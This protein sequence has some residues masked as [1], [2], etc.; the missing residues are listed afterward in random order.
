MPTVCQSV[1]PSVHQ[2]QQDIQDP[3]R[4]SHCNQHA[5]LQQKYN[6]YESWPAVYKPM[7]IPVLLLAICM[8]VYMYMYVCRAMPQGDDEKERRAQR[9]RDSIHTKSR[10]DYCIAIH[11]LYCSIH[12]QSKLNT[13]IIILDVDGLHGCSY[14][15]TCTFIFQHLIEVSKQLV[16][17]G[18]ASLAN[19]S[20]HLGRQGITMTV[21]KHKGK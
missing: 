11:I 3:D 15:Y 9:Q 14:N 20:S 13:R 8:L 19:G 21:E 6:G 10:S 12:C 16:V 18:K 1:P 2:P 4:T 7:G 17:F 5:R